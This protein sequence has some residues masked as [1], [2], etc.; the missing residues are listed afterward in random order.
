MC[1]AR[2]L[3][4]SGSH[5][6]KA[7]SSDDLSVS[8]LALCTEYSTFTVIIISSREVTT[9]KYSCKCL[10]LKVI[11][12][13]VIWLVCM[14]YWIRTVTEVGVWICLLFITKNVKCG[15]MSIPNFVNGYGE[16]VIL[17]RET[18]DTFPRWPSILFGI[19]H[20]RCSVY[21]TS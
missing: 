2:I 17:I 1:E 6:S 20:F 9:K 16:S 12:I 21:A 5:F 8:I 18:H 7:A 19:L 3:S 14:I 10:D 11:I 13:I 4:I 15:E